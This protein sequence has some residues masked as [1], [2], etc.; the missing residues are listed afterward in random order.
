MREA[1]FFAILLTWSA[2]SLQSLME[3]QQK[4]ILLYAFWFEN[5]LHIS[6]FEICC[7]NRGCDGIFMHLT[8]LII[9]FWAVGET[10]PVSWHCNLNGLAAMAVFDPFIRSQIA[11]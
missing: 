7:R 2:L 5:C 1:K 9:G 8:F 11:V 4:T 6:D 3:N 10:W